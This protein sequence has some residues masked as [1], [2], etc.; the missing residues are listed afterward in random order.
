M[1]LII[2]RAKAGSGTSNDGNT[3]RAFFRNSNESSLITGLD[4]NLIQRFCIILETIASGFEI[5][6]QVFELFAK[7][8]G[9]LYIRLYPWYFMPVTV[10]K[11]LVHSPDIIRSCILPIGQ[12]SEE[13]Q[14]ARNKDLRRIRE[15]HTRKISRTATNEDLLT[16]LLVSSDPVISTLRQLPVKKSGKLSPQVLSLLQATPPASTSVGETS[17]DDA[18]DYE[19][20]D[21]DDVSS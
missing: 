8:T 1:G 11:I 15:S 6:L 3:A 13:A 9:A 21:D 17:G 12:L 5:N 7:D 16:M 20:D 2:D 4:M 14:E 19:D 18:A 10:H